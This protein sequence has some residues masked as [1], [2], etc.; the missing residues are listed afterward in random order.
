MAFV[1]F[2]STW[3]RQP[4]IATRVGTEWAPYMS[5]LHNFGV[6]GGPNGTVPGYELSQGLP[7]VRLQWAGTAQAPTLSNDAR[8]GVAQCVS[9]DATNYVFGSAAVSGKTVVPSGVPCAMFAFAK[10]TSAT[11]QVIGGRGTVNSNSPFMQLSIGKNAL[12]TSSGAFIPLVED[13]GTVAS[14]Q[15]TG[16]AVNDG[17]FHLLVMQRNSAG[18]YSSVDGGTLTAFNQGFGNAVNAISLQEDKI[19]FGTDVITAGLGGACEIA[20]G[21]LMIGRGF[22]QTELQTL[23]L[24]PWQMFLLQPQRIHV[25]KP[26]AVASGDIVPLYQQIDGFHPQ[27]YGLRI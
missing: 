3:Y 19:A 17:I 20:Y 13:D 7:T 27:S 14:A 10:T 11:T 2:G 26:A 8:G 6:M 24:N 18:W 9:V 21:G 5:F 1:D 4:K 22:S 25:K 23:Y 12:Y 16:P 15:S